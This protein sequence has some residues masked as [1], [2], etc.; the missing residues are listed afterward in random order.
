MEA[1]AVGGLKKVFSKPESLVNLPWPYCP[2]C[3]HGVAHR[4]IAET[5]EEMGIGGRI[6]GVASIG[7]SVRWWRNTT[8]DM[9]LHC[10]G[11][12]PAVATGLRRA[13]PESI[14][15]TY[16][17]DGDLAAIGMAETVHAAARGENLSIFFINNAIYGLTGGQ[18]AP[19]TLVGQWSTSYPEGRD[20]NWA[21][22]PI[23]VCEM[24]T[25]LDGPA[26]IA[27]VSVHN[28]PNIAKAKKAVRKAFETQIQQKGF[29][30]VEFLS[31]CPTDWKLTPMEAVNWLEEQMIPYYP[32]GEFKSW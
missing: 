29:S 24:L 6:V 32:L 4:L 17:G 5:V 1:T 15:F 10:H 30:L 19:T 18:V 23:R 8:W 27:R 20:P 14:I 3:G 13:L 11:R 31:P 21:G 2:G 16:Q 7:C 9:V 26:Y 28:A 25:T 12:A 22:Y